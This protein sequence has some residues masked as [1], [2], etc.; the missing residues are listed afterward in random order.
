MTAK[1]IET[2][3]FDSEFF[4][5]NT[6][7]VSDVE[8]LCSSTDN[9][10]FIAYT[11]ELIPLVN[12]RREKINEFKEYLVS[13]ILPSVFCFQVLHGVLES[14][15]DEDELV[16]CLLHSAKQ[17]GLDYISELDINLAIG[18]I[19]STDKNDSEKLTKGLDYFFAPR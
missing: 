6:A 3:Y 19:K 2:L 7:K 4:N 1:R 11:A 14:G 10:K 18:F 8:I 15:L 16:K 9:P 12:I 13:Q 5:D 17:K